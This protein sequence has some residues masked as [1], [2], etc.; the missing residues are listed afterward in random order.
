MRFG[1]VIIVLSLILFL[2]KSAYAQSD[3]QTIYSLARQAKDNGELAKAITYYEEIY[4][5]TNNE[6]YY[7]EL[8]DLYPQV[9][10]FRS[11]EK[12]IKKRLR[13]FSDRL[14][15]Q[16]DLGYIHEL[17]K[18]EKSAQKE[19]EVAVK[20]LSA[21]QNQARLLAN[22]FNQYHKYNYAE[23][24]Y[25]KSRK[26]NRNDQLFRFEL[27]NSFAQQ[28]KSSEM[29][30]EYL[31]VLGSNRGYIQSIQNIFQRILHPDPEGK[32]MEELRQQLLKR[33]QSEPEKEVFAELLIWLYI[34]DKNFDGAYIQA[35]AI[36]QRNN[37]KGK[38]LKSLGKLAFSNNAYSAAEKSL[39]YVIDLGEE[40]PYYLSSKMLLVDVL[41]EKVTETERYVEEDLK[42]LQDI[43][44]QNIEELGK[45][46]Y[47]L[48]LLRGKAE[49]HAYY[50][51]E[52]DT[53]IQ[54][55][56]DALNISGLSEEE[57]A[58]VKI[59][60]ADLLLLS[61]DIWEASLLYSQVEKAFK[62]D[63]IGETA[64]YKNAK[65]AFYTGDFN[66][67]QA[68]LDVLK[69]S[70]S[71]LIS[72]DAMHLSTLITDNIGLDSM[73]EPLEM[74]AR[75]DLA[76][77]K[78]DYE[79]A[80]KSLDSIPKYFPATS[81]KDEVLFTQFKIEKARR[82]FEKAANNL[83][84]LIADYGEDILG[85]DA[86]FELAVL[87]EE[88][89]GNKEKAME[90]YKQL[91]TTYPSSLYVVESR[92]RFRLLRGDNL[93]SSEIPKESEL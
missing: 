23:E 90:L 33:I 47:T 24:V 48:P 59:D 4:D 88:Y 61:N 80:D 36:D 15:Y 45:S 65:I 9:E 25:L 37:E 14:H 77:F 52:V 56:E 28:G 83:R 13:N 71:K 18:D 42:K 54:I 53:A 93:E 19:Y 43:Y 38:R 21:D 91:I 34:Q 26:I 63:Q 11:A 73:P 30:E 85:D 92:K 40:S 86:L 5:K 8:I 55:L 70:T 32:Q 50:L 72:N 22:Q 2:A 64:K 78:K 76:I 57:R 6:G 31:N 67:A 1:L 79:A 68:Q 20:S 3:V 69:G 87:E 75:A 35:R 82:N 29:I 66:W 39:N 89:L 51:N 58:H 49:L 44:D 62:Y 16:V 81:L 74:Y 12:M 84:K 7:R 46:A 27:A 10:D 17:Q 41:K 60:L